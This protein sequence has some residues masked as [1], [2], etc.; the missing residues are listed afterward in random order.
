MAT[1]WIRNAI[2]TGNVSSDTRYPEVSKA[3]WLYDDTGTLGKVLQYNRGQ[4]RK[5]KSPEYKRLEQRKQADWA[6][7]NNGSGYNTSAT[8][9]ILDTPGVAHLI[10]DDVIY[11][12]RTGEMMQIQSVDYVALTI[13]VKARAMAGSATAMN[14]ND[15]V[16][17][18]ATLRPEG[19]SSSASNMRDADT[20]TNY[21][22]IIETAVEWT[23]DE[24]EEASY[25]SDNGMS[26][27]E[28][29]DK[30]QALQK[31]TWDID[32]H[33][34]KSKKSTSTAANGKKMRTTLGVI[35]SIATTVYN[36]GGGSTLTET[37][38]NTSFLELVGIA[39]QGKEIDLMCSP[40]LCSIIDGFARGAGGYAVNP[41]MSKELGVAVKTYYSSHGTVNLIPYIGL[42]GYYYGRAGV[43]LNR[44]HHGLAVFRDT[45]YK[46]DV[47][48]DIDG[49]KDL[50][51]TEVGFDTCLE[52]TLGLIDGVDTGD[53]AV[54]PGT[55]YT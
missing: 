27:R 17:R 4:V 44:R 41:G 6:R 11:I 35:P 36:H 24:L 19:S 38:F 51:R 1:T 33:L 45:A 37:L 34:F 13:T 10:P 31:H 15:W 22:G 28:A 14:D 47:V 23:G 20:L 55:T 26:S 12:P 21:A 16:L 29:H 52:E 9:F 5:V 50:W 7:I 8:T 32:N 49:R 46:K 39:N 43:A 25:L 54:L 30:K 42:N 3:S 48:S 2:A 40:R 18:I 53:A